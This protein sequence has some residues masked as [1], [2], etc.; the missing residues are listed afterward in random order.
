MTEQILRALSMAF[1]MGWEILWPLI[2]GFKNPDTIVAT[3]PSVLE[4]ACPSGMRN[5]SM[6]QHR[7][8][9]PTCPHRPCRRT[10]R[11]ACWA[12]GLPGVH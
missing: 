12:V 9:A 4:A 1:A 11:C 3:V 6:R 10:R 2:L 8:V 7:A 5:R